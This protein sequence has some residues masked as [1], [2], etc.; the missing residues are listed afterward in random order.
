MSDHDI[1]PHLH[2]PK[3]VKLAHVFH[4]QTEARFSDMPGSCCYPITVAGSR[5][6]GHRMVMSEVWELTFFFG[7]FEIKR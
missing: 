4:L 2:Y 1:V 5:N 7:I 3:Y 6:T